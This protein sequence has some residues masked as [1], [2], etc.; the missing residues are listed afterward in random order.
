MAKKRSRSSLGV[1]FWIAFILLV[2]VVFLVNR[3]RIERVLESTQ[4]VEVLQRR[5]QDE[6]PPAVDPDVT[7]PDDTPESPEQAP[8]VE[9]E[10][11]TSVDVPDALP[12][13]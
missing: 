11:D 8:P 3:P 7:Q 4:L 6:E 13:V 12:E 10:P 5:L 1:L 9:I 2:L